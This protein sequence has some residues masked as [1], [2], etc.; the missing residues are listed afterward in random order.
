MTIVI[1]PVCQYVM[2]WRNAR[3]SVYF[4]ISAA[5]RERL[6]EVI[7]RTQLQPVASIGGDRWFIQNA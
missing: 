3:R 7:V 6:L 2:I 1:N 5:S 4:S